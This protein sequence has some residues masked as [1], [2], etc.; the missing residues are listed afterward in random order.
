VAVKE[1]SEARLTSLGNAGFLVEADG[2]KIAFDPFTWTLPALSPDSPGFCGH[3]DAIL[4]TH[5]HW[6]HFHK[7]KV[8]ALSRATG[9]VVCG[10]RTVMRVL[11]SQLPAEKLLEAE[12]AAKGGGVPGL[13]V[14]AG[15]VRITAFRSVHSRD[16]TSY[17]VALGD[18]RFF[19]DGDNEDTTI[20]DPAAFRG[21]DVLLLC[22][23]N[24]SHWAE[25][26][27]SVRPRH[28]ILQHLEDEEIDLHR[29]GLFLPD[30]G[31]R[32]PMEPVALLPGESMEI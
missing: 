15:P 20:Y 23:W 5:G 24:G 6:D 7:A 30:L 9:A 19:H 18:I 17:L 11:S 28:W 14:S 3:L 29:K 12:P 1:T 10:P 31:G 25:F 13:A 16:H 26:V 21:L 8:A 32:A 27:E 22:P 2:R 4:I